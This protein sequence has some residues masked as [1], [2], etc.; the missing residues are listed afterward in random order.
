M[1]SVH[2]LVASPARQQ[3]LT[4]SVDQTIYPDKTT[5]AHNR[6]APIPTSVSVKPHE[7][8]NRMLV[9]GH[10]I[11]VLAE[12]AVT[13]GHAYMCTQTNP[14]TPMSVSLKLN[15]YS[16]GRAVPG[17]TIV[18]PAELAVATGQARLAPTGQYLH[19][20]LALRLCH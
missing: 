16:R 12:H 19:T 17:H 8:C 9:L 3:H 13:Y 11:A 10:S 4:I 2:F 5:Y 1:T 20:K 7:G 14:C 15:F 18:V 6:S